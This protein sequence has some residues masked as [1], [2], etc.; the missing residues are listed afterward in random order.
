MNPI[1]WPEKQILKMQ[2]NNIPPIAKNNGLVISHDRLVDDVGIEL[3][4]GA[5]STEG[6]IL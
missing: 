2:L 4:N 1:S 3:I 6:H 5:Y